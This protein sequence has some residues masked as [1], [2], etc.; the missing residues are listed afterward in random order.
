MLHYPILGDVVFV[1]KYTSLCCFLVFL[2]AVSKVR[3][4]DLRRA[5]TGTFAILLL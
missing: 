2:C 4:A 5:V 3:S 1:E